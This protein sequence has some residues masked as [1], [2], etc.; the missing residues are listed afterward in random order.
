LNGRA[1][2]STLLG[3]TSRPESSTFAFGEPV[4]LT[5]SV[6]SVTPGQ[7]E[8]L[9]VTVLDEQNNTI[10]TWVSSFKANSV[11]SWQTTWSA[12]NSR[13]GFYRVYA[14]LSDGTVLSGLGSRPSGYL[15]YCVVPDPATRATPTEDT[16][17]FGIQGGFNSQVN[18]LPYLGI[19]WV[20]EN[21]TWD[22]MEPLVPG[23][24]STNV[25]AANLL[26]NQYPPVNPATD[27]VTYKGVPWQI[28]TIAS[29]NGVP[30]WA[31]NPNEP[32]PAPGQAGIAISALPAFAN[33]CAAVAKDYSNNY[34]NQDKHYYSLTWEP[35]APFSFSGT[36]QDLINIYKTAYPAI[37]AADPKAV[38]IGPTHDC[39]WNTAIPWHQTL[40]N[41]GLSS[42]IDG[43]GIH[44][45]FAM[46]LGPNVSGSELPETP[47]VNGTLVGNIRYAILWHR[48][49]F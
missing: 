28:Y 31:A 24:F 14:S 26:D 13:L 8:T 27:S 9:S 16:A 49:G 5:F 22:Q 36:L 6:S 3:D 43:V 45:Y 4:V 41:M 30:A 23:Q 1:F 34:P 25:L 21:Y 48:A 2:A 39:L 7:S 44:P 18:I 19:R 17:H 47:G 32:S 33:Y 15:T 40:V 10:S 46:L 35:D 38:I 12:P 11:G 37:H 20:L 42:Y 29:M